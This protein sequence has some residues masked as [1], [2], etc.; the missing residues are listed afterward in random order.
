MK[1]IIPFI[2]LIVI[3]VL[4]ACIPAATTVPQPLI[5][6]PNAD[7]PAATKQYANSAFGLAFQYPA[8]W[9][10]PDE[11]ISGDTLRVAVGSDVVYP[12]GTD[13]TD[14]VSEGKNSYNIVIQLTKNNQNQTWQGTTQ[15]LASL[16]DGE[17]HS[18]ARSK[19][20][21][22]QSLNLGKF[23]GYEYI[24]TLSE[25]AQTEPVYMREILLTD[26]ESSLLT[27]SG[28]PN[29]VEISG[30]TNWRETYQKIDE[31]NQA[32]FEKILES[33]TIEQ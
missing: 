23:S 12:Y 11:Y 18:T 19:I 16:K 20:I 21:R 33:I 32:I 15:L 2:L 10:G 31:A 24:S 4:A 13:G 6:T 5:S 1:K 9:F 27:L 26:G 14:R 8:D 3:F 28:S 25:T 29:N 22:V 17:A 7:Q 30:G